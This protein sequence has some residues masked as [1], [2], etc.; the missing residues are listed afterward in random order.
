[1]CCYGQQLCTIGRDC[2]YFY[3]DNKYVIIEI[4]DLKM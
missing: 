4:L 1:M 3:F 2:K